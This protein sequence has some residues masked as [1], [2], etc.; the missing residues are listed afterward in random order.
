V[1]LKESAD[2]SALSAGGVPAKDVLE[3]AQQVASG[4]IAQAKQDLQG[5]IEHYT[6]AVAVEDTL[7]YSEP[8]YGITRRAN[9]S[10]LRCCSPESG[11][12]GTDSAN[13]PAAYAEQRLG[14]VR[15]H[16]SLRAARGHAQRPF[17]EKLLSQA[18][19]GKLDDLYL[20]RL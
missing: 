16:E 20:A 9:L 15:S 7:A 2:F 13:E 5:A 8:P 11:E 19:I 18:W 14:A 17:H 12:G 6:A 10:A 1:R 4:R 3:L